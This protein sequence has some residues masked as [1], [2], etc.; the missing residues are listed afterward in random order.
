MVQERQTRLLK[1]HMPAS[2]MIPTWILQA[3]LLGLF[4]G[5]YHYPWLHERRR[6]R[7]QATMA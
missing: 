2:R 1:I 4:A 7:F 6:R 3:S 5:A